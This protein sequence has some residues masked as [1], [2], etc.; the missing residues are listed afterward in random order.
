MVQCRHP[1]RLSDDGINCVDLRCHLNPP[2]NPIFSQKPPHH[3]NTPANKKFGQAASERG[4]GGGSLV[5]TEITS[6]TQKS[7]FLVQQ[8]I[9]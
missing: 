5:N 3:K 2:K 1:N 8:S 6:R 9:F 7:V 4:G